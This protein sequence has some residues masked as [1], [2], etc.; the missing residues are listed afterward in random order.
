MAFQTQRANI[1]Q[2]AFAAAF[3]HGNDVVGVPQA[4][5]RAGA[6]S[7]IEKSFQPSSASQTL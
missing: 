3:H 5:A 4:F 6:Q 2:I 7:P 1:L